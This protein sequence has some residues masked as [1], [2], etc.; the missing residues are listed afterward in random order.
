MS[1]VIRVASSDVCFVRAD[2]GDG[3]VERDKGFK[4]LQL[5]YGGTISLN[6]EKHRR[7]VISI[8]NGNS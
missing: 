4:R 2:V 7:Q 1:Q 8:P 3:D 6:S 5:S